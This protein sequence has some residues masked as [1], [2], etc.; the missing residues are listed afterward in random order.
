[1]RACGDA[2]GAASLAHSSHVE[3]PRHLSPLLK[4]LSAD[5]AVLLGGEEVPAGAEVVT[6]G[7]EGLQEPLGVAR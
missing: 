3:E 1:M 2:A 5:L 4:A 7:A 6:D